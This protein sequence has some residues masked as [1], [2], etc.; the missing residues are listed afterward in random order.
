[1]TT[2][3]M[4]PEA[5]DRVHELLSNRQRRHLLYLF[6]D[7]ERWSV[8]A[9]SMRL[10]AAERNVPIDAVAENDRR[11]VAVSLVH[12]HLPRLADYGVIE[13]DDRSGDAVRSARF[14]ELRPFVEQ[15]RSMERRTRSD[16]DL[17]RLRPERQSN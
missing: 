12:D 8:E 17:A 4:R 9:V 5:M 14:D 2:E 16:G 1:M 11:R 3:E 13:Y 7:A 10:V 6:L 15:A